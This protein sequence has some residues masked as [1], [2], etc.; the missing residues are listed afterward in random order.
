MN[1]K[2]HASWLE[3]ISPMLIWW[4]ICG[5]KTSTKHHHPPSPTG[6]F[7]VCFF[8]GALYPTHENLLTVAVYDYRLCDPFQLVIGGKFEL[9]S[10]QTAKPSTWQ[11][12]QQALAMHHQCECPVPVGGGT[13]SVRMLLS[14]AWHL[15]SRRASWEHASGLL[16][17]RP[18]AP[19]SKTVPALFA[20]HEPCW[21]TTRLTSK[22]TFC[23]KAEPNITCCFFL[24]RFSLWMLSYFDEILYQ[25]MD[26]TVSLTLR[27][28]RGPQSNFGHQIFVASQNSK[29]ESFFWQGNK[30]DSNS[31]T[32]SWR[33]TYP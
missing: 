14:R 11:E 10:L 8:D 28:R 23:L 24:P 22:K 32:A 27:V 6:F 1:L 30:V 5:D 4:S 7:K 17:C 9:A 25:T 19:G 2:D 21:F 15:T 18:S 12:S 13:F 26:S 16:S 29:L 31:M 3:Q 20:D 33:A